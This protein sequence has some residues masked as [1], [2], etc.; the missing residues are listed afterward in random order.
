MGTRRRGRELVLQSLYAARLSGA[1]LA[2]CLDDQLTAQKVADA[3][4]DFAREL[5]GKVVAAGTEPATEFKSLLRNWDPDR[6][7]LLE[8]IILTIAFVELRYSPDVPYKVVI[9]EA[10]ELARRFCDENAVAFVN[11]LL[12]RAASNIRNE[13]SA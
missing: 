12:D 10:C 3:E 7:G 9:N 1:S 5:A 2:A 11:G 4:A 8:R 6:V 13:D